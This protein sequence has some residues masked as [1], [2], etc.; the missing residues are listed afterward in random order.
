MKLPQ[1]PVGLY[2]QGIHERCQ[3]LISKEKQGKGVEATVVN[4]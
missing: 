3:K 2:Y 1:N 4:C